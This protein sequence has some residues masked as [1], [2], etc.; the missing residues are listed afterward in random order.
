V[1]DDRHTGES[2]ARDDHVI[3]ER[4]TD[5]LGGG[6][7]RARQHDVFRARGGIPAR[8]VVDED[9]ARRGHAKD[10]AERIGGANRR[11]M[12]APASDAASAAEMPSAVETEEP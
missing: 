6:S 2:T 5:D 12:E 7:D 10:A 1:R 4:D 9:E 8:V 3:E 11:A